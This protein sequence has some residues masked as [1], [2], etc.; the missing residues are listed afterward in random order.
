M[1]VDETREKCRVQNTCVVC[2]ICVSCAKCKSKNITF[3][4]GNNNNLLLLV[5]CVLFTSESQI[6]VFFLF[7]IRLVE[8][9]ELG[10]F[11]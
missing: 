6:F 1:F 8:L 10:E 5:F 7:C 2:T 4:D 3:V 11:N 9:V